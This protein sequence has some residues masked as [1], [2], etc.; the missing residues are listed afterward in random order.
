MQI[1]TTMRYDNMPFRMGKIKTMIVNVG[2]D[3]EKNRI[4]HPLWEWWV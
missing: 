4:T 3:V 1:K 2:K